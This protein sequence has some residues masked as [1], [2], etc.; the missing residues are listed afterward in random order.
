[1]PVLEISMS[2]L[3]INISAHY[4]Y[5]VQ[6]IDTEKLVILLPVLAPLMDL[7]GNA[8]GDFLDGFAYAVCLCDPV[9]DDG[10]VGTFQVHH[11]SAIYQCVALMPLLQT[12]LKA[13]VVLVV[14]YCANE[15]YQVGSMRGA[16]IPTQMY[17]PMESSLNA[18][19]DGIV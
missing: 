12:A 15:G 9:D 18:V 14:P 13:K 5:F 7:T 1:M 2:R 19:L 6:P 3:T 16:N 11:A 4:V 10:F 8:Y 17:A